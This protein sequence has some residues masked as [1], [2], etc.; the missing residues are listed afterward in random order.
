MILTILDYLADVVESTKP[1]MVYLP[2]H[3]DVSEL[4]I[5]YK[6]FYLKGFLW[7]FHFGVKIAMT[8]PFFQTSARYEDQQ[9]PHQVRIQ[10]HN[11]QKHFLKPPS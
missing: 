6:L 10:R 1:R 9:N 3:N 11:I 8:K 2:L 5:C 7:P 4:W